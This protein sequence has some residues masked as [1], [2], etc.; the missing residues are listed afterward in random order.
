MRADIILD[1]ETLGTKNGATIFQIAASSFDINTGA[2]YESIN[3]TGDI[4]KY[5]ELSVDGST[6]KWWLNTDKEL[7]HSLLTEGA[8]SEEELVRQLVDWIYAQ[9]DD[10]K[11]I[12]LW[13]NGILF[14]NVKVSN[15]CAKFGIKYPIFFRNDRDVRTILELSTIKSGMTAKEIQ[16]SVNEES[17][18]KHD[19]HDDV[20]FQIRLVRK[21]YEI[22]IG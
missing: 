2:I 9:S 11:S 1:I 3:L 20:K 13:G 17:E 15:L 22:L 18:R 10:D 4:E 12:Y 8:L 19:A 6:L 7:L 21:C 5:D 16:T 14:D